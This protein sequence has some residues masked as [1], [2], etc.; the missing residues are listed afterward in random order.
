MVIAIEM[1]GV[2]ERLTTLHN[3]YRTKLKGAIAEVA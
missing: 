1:D 3:I 2:E